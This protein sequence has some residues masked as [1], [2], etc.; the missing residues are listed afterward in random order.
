LPSHASLMDQLWSIP[1]TGHFICDRTSEICS[2]VAASI[3]MP[4]ES[5]RSVSG[6][7]NMRAFVGEI[8][9][10][11]FVLHVSEVTTTCVAFS[12]PSGINADAYMRVSMFSIGCG[13]ALA[14]GEF[15]VRSATTVSP[16][17]SSGR[18]D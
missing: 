15:D 11:R 18:N 1:H 10:I 14:V 4:V 12:R 13:R 16:G 6:H 3:S 17:F 7:L 5:S 9:D 2:N 8:N